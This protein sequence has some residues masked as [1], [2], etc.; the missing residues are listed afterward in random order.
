[1]NRDRVK[2]N[3]KQLTGKAKELAAWERKVS[4][5]WFEKAKKRL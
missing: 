3:W 2:G 4:D 1:M 5:S